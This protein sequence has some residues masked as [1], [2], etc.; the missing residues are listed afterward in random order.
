[1]QELTAPPYV[2]WPGRQ[3]LLP[4]PGFG[5][6]PSG[7][8]LT[9]PA[10]GLSACKVGI[11][12]LSSKPLMVSHPRQNKMQIPHPG[13]W[14]LNGPPALTSPTIFPSAFLFMHFAPGTLE[15][16]QIHSALCVQAVPATYSPLQILGGGSSLPPPKTCKAQPLTSLRSWFKCHLA[17]AVLPH[18]AAMSRMGQI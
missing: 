6:H 13:C 9:Q 8:S 15:A 16:H 14:A 17:R 10:H 7:V 3:H 12:D 18:K 11:P 2:P 4:S 5:P 1:M